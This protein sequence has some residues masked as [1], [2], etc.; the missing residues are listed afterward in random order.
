MWL[1]D[2]PILYSKKNKSKDLKIKGLSL[3]PVRTIC[4]R[5]TTASPWEIFEYL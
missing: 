5:S 4:A 1:K 3:G 2:H